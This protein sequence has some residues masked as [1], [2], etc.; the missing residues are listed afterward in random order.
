M[1]FKELNKK[2]YETILDS[3]NLLL[4]ETN[5]KEKKMEIGKI[6]VV[7]KKHVN[8]MWGKI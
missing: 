6:K 1:S 8:L 5:S 7:I 2:N 3:L 4:S